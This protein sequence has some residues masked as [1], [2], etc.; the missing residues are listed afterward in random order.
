MDL[1]DGFRRDNAHA[2]YT[3]VMQEIQM[4]FSASDVIA[5]ISVL[6]ASLSA[7][8][9]RWAVNATKHQNEISLHAERLIVFKGVV[10]FYSKLASNSALIKEEDVWLFHDS[11][12]LSEFYYS[13]SIYQRLKISFS[14]AS[15]SI[16]LTKRPSA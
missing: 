1:E 4:T 13:K 3:N 15:C 6:V 9:S 12:E 11:V 2:R 16:L 14:N 10:T 7:V 8:Y 5:I